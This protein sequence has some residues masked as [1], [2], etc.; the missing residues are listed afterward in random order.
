[1]TRSRSAAAPVARSL[2]ALR[3]SRLA[4][5]VLSV[6][7][8]EAAFSVGSP[9]P[10]VAQQ[11]RPRIHGRAHRLTIDS[12]PQQ[13]A[14]YWDSGDRAQPKD[15]GIAGYTPLT[16]KVPRGVTKIIVELQGWKPIEQTIDVRKSQSLT[17][18]LE[19]APQVAKLDMHAGGDGSAAG[20]DVVI[21]GSPRGT[22]PNSFDLAAG[23]HQVEVRKAGFKPFMEWIDLADGEHRTRDIALERAEAPA[24]TLL[25][26]SDAGGDVWL[27]G[28]KKDAAPAIIPGVSAGDHVVDVRKEGIPPWRQTVT[29]ASGQQTKV[30]ATFGAAAAPGGTVRI[31]SN[32]SDVQ[33]FFDGE[34]KGKA[35]VTVQNARPGDHVIEGRKAHFKNNEQTLKVN[36]GESSIVQL[37]MEPAPIERAHAT[38]KVQSTVPN[39]EVFVDGSSLGRAPVD[40]SDL[41][42]G[43]HYVSV[44][45]DGFTDFKR[46]VI[47]IE[48]QQVALV[49]DLSAT[50]TLR[51]L[52]TPEGADV[53][54]DGELV[55]KTP[56][57]R[58]GISAG[59]HVMEFRAK[60]Y[61]DHKETFKV[62]GGREK[63]LSI[64][65]KQLPTGPSPEQV[66]KRKSGMSS[67]GAKVNPTGGV[68]ADFGLGYPYYFMA[69]LTVGAFNLRG[70]GLDL[71]VEFRTFFDINELGLHGRIQLL[72]AGPLSVA[73]R[74]LLGG[75][76]G[77]N[78][79][80]SYFFDL[81]GI[82]SLAFSD[83]AS[84]FGTVRF[85][86]WSDK[87]CPSAKQ[88]QNGVDAD[89][90]CGVEGDP[91]H[92]VDPNGLFS[93]DPNNHRFSDSRLYAGLGATAVM[94]KFTSFFFQLEFLPFP[95]SFNYQPRLAYE[96]T[97]N[98]ALLASKDH[99]VYGMAGVSLKF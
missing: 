29:V 3:L 48:N 70:M 47:L 66:A 75:G 27:D 22:M 33:V 63:I 99:F 17:F 41:D 49:A 59:D 94:D 88:R 37:K 13:A 95:D 31:I 2:R 78:G 34:E 19:R 9:P 10:A 79:R 6:G 84:F 18:T 86:A 16:I 15:F 69:R 1:M 64:D 74:T 71:G 36:G 91:T 77:V 20:G 35:P 53:K 54:I 93:A 38:L 7:L 23:R 98:N 87:F 4:R 58:D 32:E 56:V 65:M 82:A 97:V 39:A 8:V 76:T 30:T 24:G 67:F 42:P 12:S 14:V 28:V 60:G 62:E 55:G 90:Y 43:K 81:I 96:G 21:D 89:T 44:H 57:L 46:E 50:G 26:V 45:K 72:E 5:L 83:V 92:P 52:S 25:V 80:D 61:F 68:T 40:R 85:S 11:P 73:A 51:I